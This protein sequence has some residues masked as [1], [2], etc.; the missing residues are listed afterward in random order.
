MSQA[1]LPLVKKHTHLG[2]YEQLLG[3]LGELPRM[4]R[5]FLI[6][7][8][9]KC[10][11]RSG[12]LHLKVVH[13]PWC[14]IESRIYDRKQIVTQ[15]NNWQILVMVSKGLHPCSWSC[16]ARYTPLI[17]ET[18]SVFV[19]VINKFGAGKKN[20]GEATVEWTI[21]VANNVRTRFGTNTDGRLWLIIP[22]VPA[23][24]YRMRLINTS[25][26]QLGSNMDCICN[27][28]QMDTLAKASKTR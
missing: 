28:I 1:A 13:G 12:A 10:S 14:K 11:G 20:S 5:R 17:L 8:G 18:S 24:C 3:V 15:L 25:G 27:L 23:W 6:T 4:S 26:N 22:S 16:Q 21:S 19:M 9:G 2:N 7:L